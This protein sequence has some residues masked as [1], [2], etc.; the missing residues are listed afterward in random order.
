MSTR[1]RPRWTG[2]N[3]AIL[4]I[5]LDPSRHKSDMVGMPRKV[6]SPGIGIRLANM[7][8]G[9]RLDLVSFRRIHVQ[10]VRY[11]VTVRG[12]RLVR[13]NVKTFCYKP[14]PRP[15]SDH[16]VLWIRYVSLLPWI[17]RVPI[18]VGPGPSHWY[19]AMLHP[20]RQPLRLAPRKHKKTDL[21]ERERERELTADI[22]S[23]WSDFQDHEADILLWTCL[24]FM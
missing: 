18:F 10:L 1:R 24:V 20:C 2:R 15:W 14:R 17:R 22:S 11:H 3:N 19:G 6:V 13:V 21:T 7:V 12:R 8:R 9:P 4:T 23:Y 16:V 5:S